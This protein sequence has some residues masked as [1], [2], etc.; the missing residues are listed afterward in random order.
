MRRAYYTLDVFTDAAARR[1]SA[2]GRARFATAS[3]TPGC[4]KSPRE[5]NLS[6]TVFVCEPKNPVN[7]ASVRIFTP[8]ARIAVRR[9]SDRRDGGAARPSARRSSAVERGPARRARREDR[10]RRLRRAPSARAGDGRLFPSA[11]PAGADRRGARGHRRAR[12]RSRAR[13]R[14][15][16]F[17]RPQARRDGRRRA[18][19][20]RAA[21]EPRRGGARAARFA[22]VGRGRRPVRYVYS[23]ETAAPTSQFHARMFAAG[24]GDR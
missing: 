8:G 19:P 3:T 4:R 20:V 16:R 24:W 21:R 12:R 15:H 2:R 5:F 6:E 17:R 14:G 13:A 1:Q 22:Q 9:P 18:A 11:A 23:R 10:R 7:T